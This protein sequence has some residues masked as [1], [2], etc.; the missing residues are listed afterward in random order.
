MADITGRFNSNV[1]KLRLQLYIKQAFASKDNQS[2]PLLRKALN[3]LE[4]ALF[5]DEQQDHSSKLESINFIR[6]NESLI[7]DLWRVFE[8]EEQID[9]FFSTRTELR[10]LLE[11]CDV[12][13]DWKRNPACLEL[14]ECSYD[15]GY[16]TQSVFVCKS[17]QQNPNDHAGFC[18]SCAENCHCG[19]EILEIGVKRN[20]RCD[21]GN[22]LFKMPCRL[23]PKSGKRNGGN[24]YSHNWDGRFCTCDQP[25]N[26]D[27]FMVQCVQCEDW[28]HPECIGMTVEK[29]EEASK[30][31][32]F[33]CHVCSEQQ[34][35]DSNEDESAPKR[36]RLFL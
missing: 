26:R 11:S 23:C 2:K 30:T 12:F 32:Y 15:R 7:R 16:I 13:P 9:A 6:N 19:H 36:R 29:V 14:T 33:K 1:A 34:G 18:E 31:S 21:C 3:E 5:F 24:R 22:S 10:D 28:F 35:Q 8:D 27:R 25:D 4:G 20:F 17:C